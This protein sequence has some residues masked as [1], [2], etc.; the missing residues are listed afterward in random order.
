M[1]KAIGSMA[2]PVPNLFTDACFS[3]IDEKL[4]CI[5]RKKIGDLCSCILDGRFLF[6]MQNCKS[7]GSDYLCLVLEGRYRR[8]PDD[9]ILEIPVWGINSRGNHAEVWK[10][11]QPTMMYSRFD[12][13]LT[14]IQRDAGIIF[15]HTENVHGTADAILALYQNFQTPPDQHNSLHQIFKA[16]TP[17]VQLV[18]PSLVRRIASELKG[19]GWEWSAIVADRFK[20]VEEMVNA[21]VATWSELEKVSNTGKRRKLGK[22]VAMKIVSSLH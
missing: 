21:D 17:T 20:S 6:Q 15:K 14:E 2:I 9:G 10:P 3:S 4:V 16:P 19:I 7:A 1:I 12:Q 18:R 11:V 5:E 8:N 22:K 13:Y